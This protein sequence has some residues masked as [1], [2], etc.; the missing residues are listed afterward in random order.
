MTSPTSGVRTGYGRA[1]LSCLVWAGTSLILIVTLLGPPPSAG[2]FGLVAGSLVV[3]ALIAALPVW[4]IARRRVAGWP[5][6]QLVL[7][8][9]PCFLVVRLL[10]T[11]IG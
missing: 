1:A 6:R 10:L 11:A 8:A 3:H 7:L 9:L 2:A 4:L 5:W